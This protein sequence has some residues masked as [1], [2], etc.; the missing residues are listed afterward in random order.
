MLITAPVFGGSIKK[1]EG[2]TVYA[3]AVHN[4][5]MWVDDFCLRKSDS[6]LII[7]NVDL[8]YAIAITSISIYGP[9][10]EHLYE[11]IDEGPI[12][13]SP[14]SSK[15]FPFPGVI[16]LWSAHGDARPN[17]IVKW[18][19]TEKKVVPPIIE[20]GLVFV[21]TGEAWG[22]EGFTTTPGT[23]LKIKKKKKFDKED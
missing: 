4:C 9:D 6:R 21:R 10:G 11:Y 12:E 2:Q 20:S 5:Y 7:R 3:P 14:L 15:T 19:V 13:I 16:P 18:E 1:Y 23:V 8:D 22:F 17:F